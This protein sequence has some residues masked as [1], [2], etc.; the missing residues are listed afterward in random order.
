MSFEI[1]NAVKEHF[2]ALRFIGKRYTNADRDAGGG[3]GEKHHEWQ[4]NACCAQLAPLGIS[5][6][7]ENGLLGLMTF[8]ADH[9][10]H[11]GEENGFAYWIGCLFPPGTS[12]PDGFSSLDLPESDVGVAW[13]R[14]DDRNGEIFG[15]EPH[16][17]S[18]Y[19]LR[20]KGWGN[21][22]ENAGGGK[23]LVFFE[24]YN[25][26]RFTTRDAQD[27]VIVDYGFYLAP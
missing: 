18:Y 4:Q 2:P 19:A 8:R 3:F 21:L 7:V 5:T 6:A 25:D 20:D 10:D 13:I 1:V 14:G 23:T 26:R 9:L 27:K 11:P 24:R 15:N 12:V 16:T 22:N 17:A